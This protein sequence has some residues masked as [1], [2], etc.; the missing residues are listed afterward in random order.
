MFW[1]AP[2]SSLYSARFYKQMSQKSLGYG[3]GYWL[4]LSFIIA[5]C[6]TIFA[7]ANLAPQ[8]DQFGSWFIENMPDFSYSATGITVN[9]EQPYEMEYPE[10]GFKIVFDTDRQVSSAADIGDAAVLITRTTAYIRSS[11][12]QY[13]EQNLINP[14]LGAQITERKITPGLIQAAVTQMKKWIMPLAFIFGLLGVLLLKL[15]EVFLYS[16]VSFV[17]GQ[18]RQEKLSYPTALNLTFFI[19]TPI[20]VAQ[21]ALFFL[22]VPFFVRVVV[23][24]GV[25]VA[26]AYAV[27]L[28][29]EQAPA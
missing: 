19:L 13:A 26:Y 9:S 15:I 2:I 8:L 20:S 17:M 18:M 24:I 25:A 29:S 21:I 3:F 7:K 28:H 22:P 12:G 16:I 14:S 10:W 4:Y 11:E 1:S 6:L 23:L 5:I 27:I